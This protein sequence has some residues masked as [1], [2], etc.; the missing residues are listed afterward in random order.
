MEQ[1]E[2]LNDKALLA[3]AMQEARATTRSLYAQCSEDELSVPYLTTINPPLWELAH[4][5]WFQEYWCLRYRPDAPRSPHTETLLEDA[6]ARFDSR[7]VAHRPRWEMPLPD[8]ARVDRYLQDTLDASLAALQR[9]PEGAP[10]E[11]FQLAV[12]HEDMHAEAIRMTHATLGRSAVAAGCDAA[13]DGG[14]VVEVPGGVHRIGS[15]PSLNRFAFDNE[16]PVVDVSLNRFWLDPRPATYADIAAFAAAGGYDRRDLWSELGWQLV[17]EGAAAPQVH[18]FWEGRRWRRRWDAVPAQNPQATAMH[19]SYHEAE[20]YARWRGGRLPSEFEW[21]V[22][23][24]RSPPLRARRPI[25]RRTRRW[26]APR[27]VDL[28]ISQE[29]AAPVRRTREGH[30]LED[31]PHASRRRV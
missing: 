16:C 6:D 5:A 25:R 12:L 8:R 10:L 31:A 22:A 7:S 21:E 19:L 26:A 4:I 24:H 20:A 27:T 30:R 18:A 13:G 23:M 29:R 28:A 1:I 9:L 14:Q 11:L 2:S 17:A 3:A 15:D